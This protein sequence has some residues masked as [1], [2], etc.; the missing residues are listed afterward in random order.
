MT[1][2]GVIL[3]RMQA[4]S[5]A[6]ATAPPAELAGPAA[7][8]VEVR[9]PRGRRRAVRAA[10]GARP[11]ARAG[12]DARGALRARELTVR[13]GARRRS[14]RCSLP[15]ASR[16]VDAL[17]RRG[18]L[19]RREDE[20]DRRV[21]RLAVTDAGLE[22]LAR[23]DGLRLARLERFAAEPLRRPARA[24]LRRADGLPLPPA[25]STG[26]T[27]W[28]SPLPDQ[29][30]QPPLVDARRDVL[31]AVHDH[32]RQHG[33]ER[34]AAVDPAGPRRV[35]R[36]P[37][38]DGQRVHADVRRAAR[39]R[40]AARRHLRPPHGV[41][42]RRR[43]LRAPRARFIGFSQTERGSSSAAPSRASAPRS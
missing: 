31:R 17:V 28:P 25:D 20:H 24:P 40:R 41:P 19:D 7:Q 2:F 27:A 42:L 33:R 32:A 23:I 43:D 26:R 22:A 11:L 1:A 34:R 13:E 37:R 3:A 15:D 6:T 14:L 5:S 10:R 39:H 21:K 29:T 12:Q 18:L 35:D 38:V 8:P 16:A 4:S 30:R 36:R 9:G